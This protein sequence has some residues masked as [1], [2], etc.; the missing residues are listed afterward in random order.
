MRAQTLPGWR[1]QATF[2]SVYFTHDMEQNDSVLL[3]I[4]HRIASITGVSLDVSACM[5][6]KRRF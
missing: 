1:P 6:R 3:D 5:Y 2:N 4:E